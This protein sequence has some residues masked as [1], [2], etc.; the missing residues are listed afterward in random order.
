MLMNNTVRS[1]SRTP[2]AGG[3]GVQ[4]DITVRSRLRRWPVRSEVIR[5][6][7]R[8][9]ADLCLPGRCGEV[10]VCLLSG[11]EMARINE[12][13]L[14][15]SGAT[16]VIT[17]DYSGAGLGL[18]AGGDRAEVLDFAGEIFIC[19]EVAAIQGAEFGVTWQKEVLR[20]LVHG[21]LH[22]A[23]YDDLEPKARKLMKRRENLLFQRLDREQGEAWT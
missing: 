15:H 11:A 23:G 20:Y 17:F 5:R 18:E 21:F 19:P 14:G 16:D 4:L 1:R 22:L 12:R 7:S 3:R 9:L 2:R 13:F 6:A 10:S 8:E